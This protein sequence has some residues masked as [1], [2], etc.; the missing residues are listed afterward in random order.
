MENVACPLCCED[1]FSNQDLLK[2]HL[3][4][5]TTNIQCPFCGRQCDD[6]NSLV[7]HLD[8][9]CTDKDDIVDKVIHDNE[10]IVVYPDGMLM[11]ILITI[12]INFIY[13]L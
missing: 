1:R 6:I 13:K 3:L 2:Y 7:V 10:M 5:L 12:L 4:S 11:K 8:K 9:M